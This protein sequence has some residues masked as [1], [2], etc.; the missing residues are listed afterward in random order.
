LEIAV[1]TRLLLK[2]KLEGIGWFTCET[3]RRITQ[4]HPE[5]HF[6]F[7]FD[8]DYDESFLFSDNVTPIILGPPARHPFLFILWFEFS[9]HDLLKKLKPDLFLSPDGYLPLRGSVPSLAVIHDINF[10]HHPKDLPFLVRKYYN[11]FFPRFAKK[12]SRIATVSEYSKKDI[13]DTYGIQA[14]QIDVV[15]N[16][17]NSVYEPISEALKQATR[18]KISQGNPYFI[19]VGSLQPRKN[20]KNLLLAFD[21]FKKETRSGIKMLIVG[22]R[23]WWNGDMESAWKNMEHGKEVIFTGRMEASELAS[24]IGAALAMT[25]MPYYEGFGI[26]ILEAMQCDVPVITSNV[27]SMPEVAKDAAILVDPFNIQDIAKAMRR[28]SEDAEL[29]KELIEKGR[30]RRADFSW[31][32]TADNLWKSIEKTIAI[33]NN[34]KG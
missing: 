19:F 32:K 3:L 17:A 12:A 14:S 29:R 2:N 33:G 10:A 28:V 7:I 18:E 25:Y 1:N 21:T 30:R 24:V 22:D 6:Y 23:Y 31:D 15:Y 13:Q 9:V 27:T 20:I 4:K 16:G 5:H 26:P 34:A 8:R 11:Y